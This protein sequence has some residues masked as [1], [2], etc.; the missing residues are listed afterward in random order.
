MRFTLLLA[1]ALAGCA[2]N[3]P[4]DDEPRAARASGPTLSIGGGIGTYYGAAAR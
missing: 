2:A 3:P 4:R 1:L